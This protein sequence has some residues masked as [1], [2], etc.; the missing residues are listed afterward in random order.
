[1]GRFFVRPSAH[2]YT[3]Y[4]HSLVAPRPSHAP[5]QA[6]FQAG[7]REDGPVRLARVSKCHADGPLPESCAS[8]LAR[9]GTWDRSKDD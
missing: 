8:S 6:C 1:M 9:L 5:R 7:C 4:T 3:R 2:F